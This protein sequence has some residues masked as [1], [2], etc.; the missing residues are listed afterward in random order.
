MSRP[1]CLYKLASHI[2]HHVVLAAR[3]SEHPSIEVATLSFFR[4]EVFYQ[5]PEH[6]RTPPGVTRFFAAALKMSGLK[7]WG[8]RL[9]LLA[10]HVFHYSPSSDRGDLCGLWRL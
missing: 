6:Q 9:R 1:S 7:T 10:L 5:E 2:R 3:P 4:G 8:L